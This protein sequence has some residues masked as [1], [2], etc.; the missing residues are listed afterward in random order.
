M[1]LLQPERLSALAREHALGTLQGGARRRFERLLND[2]ATARAEL[3]RWQDTLATLADEVP[4]LQPRPQVWQ[5]LTRRL[6]LQRPAAAPLPAGR[7]WLAG[8]VWG[9][10]LAGALASLVASTL[11]LQAYPGW[12]GHEPVRDELPASYVGLLSDAAG[13]PALLL[14]A[15]R[16]GRVLTAKLLLPLPAPV[17]AVAH[18]WA[19]PKAG[20][21]PFLVGTLPAKGS[22]RLPLRDVAETLFFPVN[23]LGVSFEPAGS[24]ATA[25][26]GPLVVSGPCVKLW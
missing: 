22:A 16:Q 11:L 9:G 17:G 26:S 13:Q 3:A 12:L 2:S 1:N 25:P 4:P 20:G 23:R 8:R 5:G 6:G 19:F 18:L 10:V 14:S 24:T 21:T 15:R 7:Q